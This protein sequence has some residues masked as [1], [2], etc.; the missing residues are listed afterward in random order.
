MLIR[1]EQV[2]ICFHRTEKASVP[3]SAQ[4]LTMSAAV[5]L[6]HPPGEGRDSRIVWR[7]A[8]SDTQLR[9]SF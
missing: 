1:M 6:H 8:V 3:Q 4:A 2:T 5:S 9:G 7:I